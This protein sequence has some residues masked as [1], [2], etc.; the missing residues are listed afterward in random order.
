MGIAASLCGVR[1]EFQ[2]QTTT[3][4]QKD[5]LMRELRRNKNDKGK[6]LNNIIK[7]SK[8]APITISVQQD[9]YDCK[10]NT[11]DPPLGTCRGI[12][13]CTYM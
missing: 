1:K 2:S 12:F 11:D 9:H 13:V 7:K 4:Y 10:Y 3:D 8:I 6:T 5:Q